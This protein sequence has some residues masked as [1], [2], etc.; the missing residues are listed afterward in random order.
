MLCSRVLEVFVTSAMYGRNY[1]LRTFTKYFVN[2]Y[3]ILYLRY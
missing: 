3:S 2:N 1:A